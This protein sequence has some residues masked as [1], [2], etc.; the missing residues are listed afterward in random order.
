[1]V[2]FEKDVHL[3][4]YSSWYAWLIDC[5]GMWLRHQVIEALRIKHSLVRNKDEDLR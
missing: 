5:S 3:V 1:M 2:W 4:Y